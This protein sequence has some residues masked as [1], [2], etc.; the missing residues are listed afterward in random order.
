MAESVLFE[1]R[2]QTSVFLNNGGGITITQ[3]TIHTLEHESTVWFE[4]SDIDALCQRLQE[5]KQEILTPKKD[6]EVVDAAA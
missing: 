3:D 4:V 2:P 5:L 1:A 6:A